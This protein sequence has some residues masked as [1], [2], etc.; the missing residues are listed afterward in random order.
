MS[1]AAVFGAGLLASLSPCVYPLLPITLG[2]FG[3]NASRRRTTLVLAYFLGQIAA[4]V[5]V[6]AATVAL[7]ETL[8]FTSESRWANLGVGAV[9]LIAGAVSLSGNLP[10]FLSR[11]VPRRLPGGLTGALLLGV[12]SAVVAS[13]CTSPILAGV[14]ATLATE[15]SRIH[16]ILLMTIYASGFSALFLGL[17]LGLMRLP[18]SG[19][20]LLRVQHASALLLLGAGVYY[21]GQAL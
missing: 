11:G 5:T 9:L 2:F 1:A 16:G 21:V 13:P 10:V 18:R 4:F 17:S 8:G 6:G 14:L 15:E 7:G 19:P 12:G 3:A 20:W